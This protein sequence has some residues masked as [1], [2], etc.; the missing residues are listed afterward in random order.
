MMD[1]FKLVTKLF[2]DE[3]SMMF[4]NFDSKK[5]EIAVTCTICALGNRLL[6]E[7]HTSTTS[8]SWVQESHRQ[9]IS[10]LNMISSGCYSL[11]YEA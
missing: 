11:C 5:I 7:S 3:I 10:L 1:D 9:S 8:V 6:N 4:L 2:L